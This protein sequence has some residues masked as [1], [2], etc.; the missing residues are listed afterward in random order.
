MVFDSGG[1]P[2]KMFIGLA[3]TEQGIKIG[4]VIEA[5]LRPDGQMEVVARISEKFMRMIEIPDKYPDTGESAETY[6]VEQAN[7]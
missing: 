7:K 5:H 6:D 2:E 4:E 3:V 1:K